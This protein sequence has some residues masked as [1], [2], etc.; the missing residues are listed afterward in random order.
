MFFSFK[1]VISILL[2]FLALSA[3][4]GVT[5]E[6][7]IERLVVLL[8]EVYDRQEEY[9]LLERMVLKFG[10]ST[11]IDNVKLWRIHYREIEKMEIV[12]HPR[13]VKLTAKVY[14]FAG[15]EE[16]LRLYTLLEELTALG[17]RNLN[18]YYLALAELDWNFSLDELDWEFVDEA[19]SSEYFCL[20]KL[21]LYRRE[22]EVK[23]EIKEIIGAPGVKRRLTFYNFAFDFLN[24]IRS[25]I[26]KRDLE[27]IKRLL[28]N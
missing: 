19:M 3:L 22:E 1:H 23:R 17:F 20:L 4:N 6:E 9:S 12:L 21:E 27:R 5:E 13:L 8:V 14:E 24:R 15:E 26:I 7:A 2:I 10:R 18:L 11:F 25:S 16:A 28:S